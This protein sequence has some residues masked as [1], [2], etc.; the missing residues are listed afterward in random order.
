M[1]KF[2]KEAK[3]YL[4][5]LSRDE[6]KSLLTESGFEVEDG[7]GELV[8]TERRNLYKEAYEQGR[9]DE[10]I[11]LTYGEG[12]YKNVYTPMKALQDIDTHIQST[13]DPVP[14]I[15]ETLKRVLP[16]YKS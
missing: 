2:K 6:L 16:E 15:I 9:F 8:F 12:K 1:N 10:D 7:N 5:N 4:N 14:Y 11:E 13:S 3:G